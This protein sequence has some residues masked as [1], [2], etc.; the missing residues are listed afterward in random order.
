M[1]SFGVSRTNR[2]SISVIVPVDWPFTMTLAPITGSPFASFTIPVTLFCSCCIPCT[3]SVE[4]IIFFSSTEYFT[5]VPAKIW[6]SILNI[7]L[8]FA[9]TDTIRFKSTCLLLKKKSNPDSFFS[10]SN[11]VPTVSLRTSRLIMVFCAYDSAA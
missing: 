1:A 7:L 3:I 10:F 11:T 4:R 6:S 2:P 5:F 9:E 8:L